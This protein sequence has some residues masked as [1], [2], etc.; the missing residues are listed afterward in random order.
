MSLHGAGS[1]KNCSR[2]RLARTSRTEG[3]WRIKLA[4]KDVSEYHGKLH[5]NQQAWEDKKRCTNM[6]R[7]SRERS[8]ALRKYMIKGCRCTLIAK[9]SEKGRLRSRSLR[10]NSIEKPTQST[11]SQR[12]RNQ[13]QI[14]SKSFW[15][16]RMREDAEARAQSAEKPVVRLT[17]R[18]HY[19]KIHQ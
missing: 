7:Q 4:L 16:T 14:S 5:S 19:V 2:A 1:A 12:G 3:H 9:N 6:Q 8:T 13:G 17:Q 11:S 10:S 15:K 18:Q